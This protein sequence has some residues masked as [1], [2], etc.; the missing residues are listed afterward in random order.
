MVLKLYFDK[1]S[2]PSRALLMF[3]RANK[4]VIPCEE[5]PV[6]L[7]KGEHLNDKFAQI[8]PFQKVPVVEHND[9]VLT[10]RYIYNS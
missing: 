7:R 8:N 4:S 10:E 5:M 2:Q 9:F 1:M 6:A 3:V